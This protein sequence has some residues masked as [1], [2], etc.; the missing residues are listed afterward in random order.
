MRKSSILSQFLW[1]FL[2]Q[3]LCALLIAMF[4]ANAH[5][6]SLQGGSLYTPSLP[7]ASNTPVPVCDRTGLVGDWGFS[8]S[9]GNAQSNSRYVLQC[10]RGAKTIQFIFPGIY[11]APAETDLTT[12]LPIHA[13]FQ[14]VTGIGNCTMSNIV[15]K[16]SSCAVIPVTFNGAL[17]GNLAVTP[18]SVLPGFIASDAIQANIPVNGTIVVTDF[19]N[20]ATTSISYGRPA[21]AALGEGRQNA[22][23][24]LTDCSLLANCSGSLAGAGYMPAAV[25]GIPQIAG[26]TVTILGDSIASGYAGSTAQSVTI[27]SGGTGYVSGD[28][29]ATVNVS[30]GTFATAAQLTITTVSGGAVTG[31]SITNAGQYTTGPG[32]GAAVTGSTTGSGLTV[33][34]TVNNTI[35][36][37]DAFGNQGY[38]ERAM[39]NSGIPW[40]RIS[41]SGD[42]TATWITRSYGRM[43][44]LA[45][46][47]ASSVIDTLDINDI[48]TATSLATL[49][50]NDLTI[51]T[52][53]AATGAKVFT[54]T[55][56]PGAVSST[57]VFATTA[58]QTVYANDANRVAFNNWIRC[59]A[60]I[61]GGAAV[62][63][64][65]AS[66]LLSGQP[67]HPLTGYFE[68]AD[69]LESARDSGKFFANGTAGYAT[70]DG[71]HFALPGILRA[72]AGINAAAL[73]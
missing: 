51:W 65:T 59:G 23:S 16:T 49:Q 45:A 52:R 72:A 32:A 50:T 8:N 30:G 26:P 4:A 34:L 33:T 37:G 56:P 64:G 42:K 10:P 19:T 46:I 2:W 57:D 68:I 12:Q 66:A 25:I 47:H 44:I 24:G 14:I 6:A 61:S 36:A 70:Y 73:K 71:T 3:F 28:V 40:V 60:P 69:T 58:N 43:G 39:W 31:V 41:R 17:S 67:G 63:C 54:I 38:L 21:I 7:S 48:T 15:A 13:G 22:A 5:A 9:S 35:E 27:A 11:S 18:D 29:G 62:A 1:Q 55:H 53:L 20:Q